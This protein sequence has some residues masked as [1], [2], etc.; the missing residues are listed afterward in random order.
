MTQIVASGALISERRFTGYP[1]E[2]RGTESMA[3][4]AI[5][6]GASRGIGAAVAERLAKDDFSVV[7]NYAGSETEAAALVDEI[8]SAGGRAIPAK[9]DVSKADEVSRMFEVAETEFEGVDVLV[10]N[11]GIMLQSSIG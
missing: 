4:A 6:T 11:A 5:I 8:K 3:R 2:R 10:N 9:A 7:V 1:K